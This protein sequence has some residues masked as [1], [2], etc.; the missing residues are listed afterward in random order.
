[1]ID[2]NRA[3]FMFKDGSMAWEAKDFLI[4][5][6]ECKEVTIESKSYYGKNYKP[7]V[8]LSKWSILNC[9]VE[10]ITLFH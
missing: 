6:E 8:C 5:Q 10:L 1:M 2:D 3:I 7:Q 4:Q 9:L